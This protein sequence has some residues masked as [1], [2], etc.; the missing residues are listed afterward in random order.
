MLCYLGI[1][2]KGKIRCIYAKQ[3]FGDSIKRGRL[4]I[5][6]IAV[7]K[8]LVFFKTILFRIHKRRKSM[9]LLRIKFLSHTGDDLK[10][11][12]AVS[13]C[14]TLLFFCQRFGII[15]LDKKSGPFV[16]YLFKSLLRSYPVSET[17]F[18]FFKQNTHFGHM[19]IK[20]IVFL[21]LCSLYGF[22]KIKASF[23]KSL[24]RLFDKCLS[25]VK[26]IYLLLCLSALFEL[27]L[28]NDLFFGTGSLYISENIVFRRNDISHRG[29]LFDIFYAYFDLLDLSFFG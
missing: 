27:I 16:L 19:D 25:L 4:I 26:R 5:A 13:G 21:T 7:H 10:Y 1:V 24:F 29:I 23:I 22:F 17:A 14:I 28:D 8:C 18:I 20:L 11:A 6:Q 15:G 9:G 12:F 3:F 2:I